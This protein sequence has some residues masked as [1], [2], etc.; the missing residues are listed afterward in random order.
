[1][2]TTQLLS[3]Q[4]SKNSTKKGHCH[5]LLHHY[6]LFLPNISFCIPWIERKLYRVT[7]RGW[8]I[9][10]KLSFLMVNYSFKKIQSCILK[11]YFSFFQVAAKWFLVHFHLLKPHP[12][13]STPSPGAPTVASQ[14]LNS[15]KTR[16]TEPA[17]FTATGRCRSFVML[18]PHVHVERSEF[19][20][21]T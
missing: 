17:L 20:I 12:L 3:E 1:M 6:L 4:W 21:C 14:L 10:P 2:E 13:P 7:T 19:F 8:V 15:P 11:I 18:Q 16:Y 5:H 9:M